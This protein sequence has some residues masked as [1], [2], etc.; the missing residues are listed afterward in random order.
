MVRKGATLTLATD[1]I[2]R[3]MGVKA[4]ILPVTDTHVEKRIE[5]ETGDL[6]FQEFWVKN[7]GNPSV[8]GVAYKGSRGARV[9]K[10][11]AQALFSADRIILCPA[12]PVT[13]I[14]PMLAIPGF[15]PMLSSSEGKISALSPM[16]GSSPFSGPALKLMKATGIRSDS[17]GVA[18]L[19]SKF[20][21]EILISNHDGAMKQKIESL[22]VR[23]I[24]SNTRMRT[25]ADEVRLARELVEN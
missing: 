23:C 12:N 17:I 22:G 19:Y 3:A 21:D 13:S 14:G 1:R 18:T 10:S 9:T 25:E 16:Y 6:H 4:T 5:T 8:R 24:T 15:A 2:R 20:L 7:G 11:V